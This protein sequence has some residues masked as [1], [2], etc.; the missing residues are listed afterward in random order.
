MSTA[1]TVREAR[2][3]AIY[4]AADAYVDALESDV[5]ERAALLQRLI[6]RL[7]EFQRDEAEG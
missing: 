1:Q 3:L 6:A 4:F 7:E 5:T 2:L